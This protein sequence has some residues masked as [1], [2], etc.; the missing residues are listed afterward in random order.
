[1]IEN[2]AGSTFGIGTLLSTVITQQTRRCG[3]SHLA[4]VPSKAGLI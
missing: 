3:L 1:M 2:T 4:S